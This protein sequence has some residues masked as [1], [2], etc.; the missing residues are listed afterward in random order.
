MALRDVGGAAL[1][2]FWIVG[3]L[4]I[5][6]LLSLLSAMTDDGPPPAGATQ[7]LAAAAQPAPVPAEDR[8]LRR[9]AERRQQR[10]VASSGYQVETG[11]V[12]AEPGATDRAM[13]P[14]RPAAMIVPAPAAGVM[15]P[16]GFLNSVVRE[17]AA[18]AAGPGMVKRTGHVQPP[19]R[20]EV[21]SNTGV[22]VAAAEPAPT[23]A[24][25]ASAAL[26]AAPAN[27][28]F[29]PQ[30]GER[31]QGKARLIVRK[32]VNGQRSAS[33]PSRRKI[34]RRSAAA[35]TVWARASRNGS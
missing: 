3:M 30:Q 22:V 5:A 4:A 21:A 34:A 24:H 35:A 7:T 19:A 16:V 27:P 17:T 13:E 25:M 6:G 11:A 29:E 23:P 9:T 12:L 31:Q 14:G 10:L 18:S 32:H 2:R 28:F 33:S 1:A 15:Q 26:V 8:A 20:R